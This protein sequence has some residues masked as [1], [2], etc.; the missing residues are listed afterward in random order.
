MILSASSLK[1]PFGYLLKDNFSV[2]QA[3]EIKT[4]ILFFKNPC[5][6]HS[7]TLTAQT[8]LLKTLQHK[9]T[10][11]HPQGLTHKETYQLPRLEAN[12]VCIA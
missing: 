6:P 2:F 10:E 5:F 9:S 11:T 12:W 7:C 3:R 4:I 1:N 8:L